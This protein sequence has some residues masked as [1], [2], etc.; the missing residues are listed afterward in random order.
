MVQKQSLILLGPRYGNK[1]FA[2]PVGTKI[3][4][5]VKYHQLP[6][7]KSYMGH[8]KPKRTYKI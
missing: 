4:T 3:K 6:H 8:I 5:G 7:A 2:S 1:F